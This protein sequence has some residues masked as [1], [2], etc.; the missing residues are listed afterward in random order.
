MP[1][2]LG[3][4]TALVLPLAVVVAEKEARF[5]YSG[6]ADRCG[7]MPSHIGQHLD[8]VPEHQPS[9]EVEVKQPPQPDDP[10]RQYHSG[11]GSPPETAAATVAAATAV[12]QNATM[13]AATRAKRHRRTAAQTRA[14]MPMILA[15]CPGLSDRP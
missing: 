1:Q 8:Q 5:S 7:D 6:W 12:R 4:A 2:L 15:Q 14:R 13:T 11:S 3:A 10:G 9:G